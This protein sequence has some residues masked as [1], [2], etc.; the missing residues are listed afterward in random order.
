[1]PWPLQWSLASAAAQSKTKGTD[2]SLRR[3]AGTVLGWILLAL[4]IAALVLPGPGLLLVL[5]GLVLL[6]QRYSWAARRVEP[7]KQRAYA[8]SRES[9]S[10][11]PRIAG[12]A[13]AAVALIAVGVVWAFD[14]RIRRIGPLGPH[15]P[16]AGWGTGAS[17]I[18]SGMLALALVVY[19][20][21]RFR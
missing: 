3:A 15:L 13:L 20:V 5:V 9:V 14:V 18:V 11:Y 6:S 17:L 2:M 4:G 8:L 19:S 1:V 16:L 21:V 12:S 10:T 7:V